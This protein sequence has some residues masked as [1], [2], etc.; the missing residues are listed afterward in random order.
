MNIEANLVYVW[1]KGEIPDEICNYIINTV[2]NNLYQEGKIVGSRLSFK[3]NVNTQFTYNNWINAMLSGYV[4]YANFHNFHYDLSDEDKEAAQISKYSVGEYY[5]E[6]VDFGSD[7]NLTRK[8]SL[9]IQLSDENDYEGGDLLFHTGSDTKP[10]LRGKGSVIVF[11]SRL[12]HEITPI[13]KGV[14]YSLVKWYH[15]DKPLK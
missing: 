1:Q 6:H 4:R 15:G 11:D 14:R 9:T 10:S 13:T 5:G 8:L 7:F 3:R 12:Y 2:D